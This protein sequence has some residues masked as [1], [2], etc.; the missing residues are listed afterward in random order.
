MNPAAFPAC[1]HSWQDQVEIRETGPSPWQWRASW[2][3][4]PDPWP[5]PEAI[6]PKELQTHTKEAPETPNAKRHF[7]GQTR[8]TQGPLCDH[9]L[10]GCLLLCLSLSLWL[11]GTQNILM[12]YTTKDTFS[13]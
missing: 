5:P 11:C 10:S 9:I 7:K 3:S 13:P 2:E 4:S 8:A 1:S 12:G 6:H